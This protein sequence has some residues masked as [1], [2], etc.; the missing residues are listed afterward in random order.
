MEKNEL[1]LIAAIG[2]FHRFVSRYFYILTSAVV[3]GLI[4][5]SV[6]SFLSKSYYENTL[7][8]IAGSKEIYIAM[9]G[10]MD[11]KA[12]I[13]DYKNLAKDFEADFVRVKNIRKITVKRAYWDDVIKRDG[14]QSQFE[15]KTLIYNDSTLASELSSWFYNLSES[16]EYMKE[17]YELQKKQKQELIKKYEHE[18]KLLDSAQ[19][20]KNEIKTGQIVLE[21]NAEIQKQ[22]VELFKQKLEIESQLQLWRPLIILDSSTEEM[23]GKKMK[24]IYIFPSIFLLLTALFGVMRD[25]WLSIKK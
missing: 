16:N 11:K 7:T 13:G 4:S 5:G 3:L 15:I 25:F 6:I 21:N 17:I 2:K 19:F 22:K 23:T 20:R 18:L 9:L 1:D 14:E 24:Y 10:K 12:Q 8:V